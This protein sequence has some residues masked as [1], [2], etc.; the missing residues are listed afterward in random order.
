MVLLGLI[1]LAI[2]LSAQ[3][4]GLSVKWTW[5]DGNVLPQ[6]KETSSVSITLS[7]NGKNQIRLEFVGL[8]FAWMPNDTYAYGGGSEKTNLMIP[9]QSITYT[10]PFA[11]P[12]DISAG[13]YRSYAAIIYQVG[14]GTAWTK[15]SM[16]YYPQQ[17]LEIVPMVV[18]T[19]TSTT[20]VG[21]PADWTVD[22]AL[23]VTFTII[24]LA[25]L[26]TIRSARKQGKEPT[27][28]PE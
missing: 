18:V 27:Q 16:A 24:G 25:L 26:A 10:I 5:N 7:N 28:K 11:I 13:Q 14:N 2:P 6:S 19:V 4:T 9:G 1:L 22:L 12:K 15:I 17:T 20:T 21:Q 3:E 23:L 8:H